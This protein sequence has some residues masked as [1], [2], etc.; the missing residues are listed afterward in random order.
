MQPDM[1]AS[2]FMAAALVPAVLISACALL[3]LS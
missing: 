2:S 3:L 1:Q